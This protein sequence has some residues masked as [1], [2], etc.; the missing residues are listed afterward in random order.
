MPGYWTF[1]KF[2]GPS[3]FAMLSPRGMNLL[4]RYGLLPEALELIAEIKDPHPK[5]QQRFRKCWY[6]YG[7]SMR[8]IV[9]DDVTF[10]ALRV[11]LPPYDGPPLALYRGQVA[12]Q[13]VGPSW[14][15]IYD[16]AL[17]FARDGL[18][19]EQRD[20]P[21]GSSPRIPRLLWPVRTAVVLKAS[22]HR[23]IISGPI[24]PFKSAVKYGE[25]VVDPR[26]VDY[27]VF[28]TIDAQIKQ[29]AAQ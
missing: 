22:M 13:W 27:E 5:A 14:T 4:E 2:P 1:D 7:W 15:T 26:G 6:F 12:G 18:N 28:E 25:H 10:R 9:D 8:G 29:E 24:A 23:E 21:D 16:I 19:F 3:H 20:I 17:G 11:L